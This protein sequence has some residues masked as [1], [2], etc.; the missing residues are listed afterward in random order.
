MDAC[1]EYGVI[2]ISI[3]QPYE[4][5]ILCLKEI[6]KMTQSKGLSR[7]EKDNGSSVQLSL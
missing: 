2:K 6:A 3:K 7:F 1:V 4:R 5:G